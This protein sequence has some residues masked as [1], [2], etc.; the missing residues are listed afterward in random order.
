MERI[1]YSLGDIVDLKQGL[2][3]NKKTKHLLTSFSSMPL[4]KIRD[5][6]NNTVE[7]YVKEDEVPLQ[8]IAD[9]DDLIY[10]RTGQVG[11]V[12]TG[13]K[14]CV[15][16]NCFKIIP[17]ENI[18]SRDYLYWFLK[19]PKIVRYANNIASGSVQKDLNHTAFKSIKIGIPESK[20]EQKAIAVILSAFDDKI[21][22][23]LQMNKTLEAMAMALY[24]H[25]FVDFGPFQDGVFVDSELGMI[26]EGWEVRPLSDIT[27]KITD[28]AHHSPKSMDGG[29]LMASVKDMNNWGFNLNSCRQISIEDYHKLSSQGCRPLKDDVLI[30]KDGSYLK[31]AFVVEK[32]LDIVLLSSIAILRPNDKLDP[33]LLNLYLK[34]NSVKTRMESIVSGAAIQRIVLKEFRK[35]LTIV[36]PKEIQI[37]ALNEIK[38]LIEKCWSNN[39][40]IRI[41]TKLR[42]TLL[43]KLISGEVRVKDIE[44][45]I[46]SAL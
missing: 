31:H 21:E 13:K 11:L 26:P 15:H 42:D 38:V 4:F 41:L 9:I 24:K 8:C 29:M 43:P 10:T 40:E 45:T 23:N 17:N 27:S 7:H 44:K 19:Q 2:A 12:F 14:G 22:L 5:L 16:N 30:A 28:G 6:I 1:I 37:K 3:I 36:P 34:L 35:F 32:D 25:W 46:A 18:L 39:S 33:Q 20:L